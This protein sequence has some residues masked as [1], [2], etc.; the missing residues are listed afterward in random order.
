MI[1]N[2]NILDDDRSLATVA[3]I[4]HMHHSFSVVAT[5]NFMNVY[6]FILFH[7]TKLKTV[8]KVSI[9]IVT[10]S[11]KSVQQFLQIWTSLCTGRTHS[12]PWHVAVPGRT[13]PIRTTKMSLRVVVDL[14]PHPTRTVTCAVEVELGWLRLE[15]CEEIM[16]GVPYSAR[17]VVGVAALLTLSALCIMRKAANR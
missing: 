8:H 13:P 7:A 6:R 11:C 14:P 5:P 16:R 3:N 17:C 1:K 2:L 15:P 9:V 12:V 4:P 10:L